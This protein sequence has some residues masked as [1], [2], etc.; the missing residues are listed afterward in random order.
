VGL[1]VA[2]LVI[3]VGLSAGLVTGVFAMIAVAVR[4]EDR[5][6]SLTRPARGLA[7]RGV[8]RLTGVGTR[9]IT[10]SAIWRQPAERVLL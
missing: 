4:K 1:M 3:G 7:A 5:Q 8:R 10:P 6:N 2:V 9:D